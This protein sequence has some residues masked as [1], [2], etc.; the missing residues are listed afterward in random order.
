MSTDDIAIKVE[1]LSKC[2]QIY[3][4]PRDRLKQFF[5]PRVRRTLGSGTKYH[6]REFW[7]LRDV[8]FEVKRGETIGI[9]GRN[10]SGKSTLL[11]TVC[12]VLA[13]SSGNVVINGRVAALLELGSGFNPEFTGMENVKLYASI[14]GLSSQ[15]ISDRIPEILAFAD[16]GDFVHQPIKTYSS[17]MV[18]RLAFSAIIHMNP[19]ILVVDEALAVGDTV[20]QQKC[21]SRIRQMQASGVSILLVTHSTNTVIEY[22]DRA[23]FLKNGNL[24]V[25]GPCREV[26]KAYVDDLVDQE[27]GKTT[28]PAF[29]MKSM[30]KDNTLVHSVAT[31]VENR[32]ATM[33]LEILEVRFTDLHGQPV[34]SANYGN[35]LEVNIRLLVHQTV[36]VPSTGIQISSVDGI[37]L[38]SASSQSL[39][40]TIE[41]LQPGFH[42]ISWRLDLLFGGGRYIFA[43]GAGE[44]INGEYR[45]YHR[46]DCAGYID[47]IPKKNEGSGWLAPAPRL[48]VKSPVIE[49]VSVE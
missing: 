40:L 43:I 30:T 12:G 28:R 8:S 39:G 22:C 26:V 27:G 3:D 15:E 5:L 14:L 17:G 37:A 13:Q 2:Y 38:W 42:L 19:D 33:P 41:R 16:I 7:A 10:G 6:Y 9:I 32:Q 21:L 18:V 49:G 29:Q 47:I 36:E 31:I 1:N 4:N 25:D 11:Q 48:I 44:I 35:V 24:I 20:F 34:V 45:R 23:L 46:L